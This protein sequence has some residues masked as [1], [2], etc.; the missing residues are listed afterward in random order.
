MTLTTLEPEY[1]ESK[2]QL[3]RLL[4]GSMTI[5]PL[6]HGSGLCL[7]ICK[8]DSNSI[9]LISLSPGLLQCGGAVVWQ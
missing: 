8:M 2:S 1:V 7:P 3:S 9:Y 6:F 4:H 5:D